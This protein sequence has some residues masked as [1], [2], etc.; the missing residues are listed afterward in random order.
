MA[1]SNYNND[2]KS[3]KEIIKVLKI[4]EEQERNTAFFDFD[5]KELLYSIITDYYSPYEEISSS[6]MQEK[7]LN[8]GEDENEIVYEIT[9]DFLE[10]LKTHGFIEDYNVEIKKSIIHD[11][12]FGYPDEVNKSLSIKVDRCHKNYNVCALFDLYIWENTFDLYGTSLQKSKI[13]E[14]IYKKMNDFQNKKINLYFGNQA[15]T[16]LLKGELT[17]L[18]ND[19]LEKYV[20]R[21]DLKHIRVAKTLRYMENEGLLKINYVNYSSKENGYSPQEASII[22]IN[23]EGIK[24]LIET[25]VTI[26]DKNKQSARKIIFEDEKL[27]WGI[28]EAPFEKGQGKI[29]GILYKDR[30]ETIGGYKKNGCP[31]NIKVLM[32]AGGYEEKETFLNAIAEMNA[33][34]KKKEIPAKIKSTL[35]NY[36]MLIISY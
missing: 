8:A 2:K 24:N 16:V 35:K 10:I 27:K 14:Y 26:A 3:L 11:I 32:K 31:I 30:D 29:M 25:K 1:T 18:P 19:D 12:E 15:Q 33:K 28:I 21:S 23:K 20:K 34:F 36:R 7:V 5:R 22:V 9:K 17:G 13:A 4:L 6:F